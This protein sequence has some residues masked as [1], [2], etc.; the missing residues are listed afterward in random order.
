MYNILVDENIDLSKNIEINQALKEFEVKSDIE[1]VKQSITVSP[2]SDSPKI[3]QLIMK[4]SGGAIKDERQAEYVLLG[5][6]VV[7]II[8]SLFLVFS[9]GG[10]PNI[11]LPRGAKIIYPQNEPPRLE[12]PIMP[13]N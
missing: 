12:E 9:G 6:V 5:F 3:V 7:A 11:P 1:Q 13:P 10:G 4:I 8:V 2:T